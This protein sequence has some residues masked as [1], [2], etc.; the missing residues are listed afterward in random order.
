RHTNRNLYFK[1]LTEVWDG[2][3]PLMS[4]KAHLVCRIGTRHMSFDEMNLRLTQSVHQIWPRSKLLG[5]VTSGL[6]NRQTSIILP[7]A[8]GCENEYD[9]TFTLAA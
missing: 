4:K 8:A 3:K 7:N 2:I 9:F 1:F 6:R 5:H